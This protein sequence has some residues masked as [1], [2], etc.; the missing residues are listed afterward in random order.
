MG[1]WSSIPSAL[2]NPRLDQSTYELK[3]AKCQQLHITAITAMDDDIDD[4]DPADIDALDD[5]TAARRRFAG[6]AAQAPVPEL[7]SKGRLR[8]RAAVPVAKG[9]EG[10]AVNRETLFEEAEEVGGSRM[11]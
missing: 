8:L 2:P 10:K 11:D 3:H 4:I 1:F 7:S 6:A 9:Y 5:Q